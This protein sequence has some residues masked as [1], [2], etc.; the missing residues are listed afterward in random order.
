MGAS[1]GIINTEN[2]I[3]YISYPLQYKDNLYLQELQKYMSTKKFYII[4]SENTYESL[5]NLEGNLIMDN[6]KNVLDKTRYFIICISENTIYSYHQTVEINNSIEYN[7]EILYLITDKF[8][9]P[10]NNNFVKSLV[11]NKKWLLF[12][13]DEHFTHCSN[14]LSNIT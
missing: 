14:Y 12:Y 1:N 3:I 13:T 4:N 7:K 6:I 5:Q 8:C 2:K 9:E 10:E 11:N